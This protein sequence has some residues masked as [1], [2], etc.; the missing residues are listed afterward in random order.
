MDVDI[1]KA[2]GIIIKD[3][4][5]LSLRSKGG[6]IFLNPGGKL[7]P[8]ESVED[9]LIREL[10]EELTI[11]VNV[12]DAEHLDTYY[13]PAATK[14]DKRLRMDAFFIHKYEGELK[15]SNEIEELRWLDSSS[16]LDD[17]ASLIAHTIIPVLKEKELID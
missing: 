8:G 1:H 17:V 14:P 16:N 2:A 6:S 13:A 3:R 5:V 9:A 10:F 12:Q 7:D 11:R 4:K 15:A